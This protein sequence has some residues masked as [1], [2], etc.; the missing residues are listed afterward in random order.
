MSHVSINFDRSG[1]QRDINTVFPIDRLKE[2]AE[3]GVIGAVSD[4]HFSLMGATEPT[5][6]MESVESIV[7]RVKR[8]QIDSILL[9]P[10]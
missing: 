10:V 4:V 9:S 8:D 2:L 5:K 3:D 7:A 6:M 1:W